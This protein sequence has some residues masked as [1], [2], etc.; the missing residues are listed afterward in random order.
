MALRAVAV[1]VGAV[2]N[3]RSGRALAGLRKL[4]NGFRRLQ[5][6]AS[7]IKGAL[8]GFG[9]SLTRLATGGIFASVGLGFAFRSAAQF[10][11]QMSKVQAVVE[12]AGGSME[13]MEA[14]AK[15]LG[16]TTVFSA[17]QA[18]EGMELMARAGFETGEILGGIDGI[19]AAAA[20]EGIT[21]A[22]ATDVVANTLKGMGIEA[23]H[24]SEVADILALTS[25]KTNSTIL[26]LGEGMKFVAPKARQMNVSVQETAAAL[27]LL[28]N[29][30][31]KGTLAGTGLNT[32]LT[33]LAKPSDTIT[34]KMGELGITFQDANGNMLPLFEVLTNLS[35][36]LDKMGGN[37]EQAAFLTELFGLRGEKAAANL[38]GVFQ[39]LNGETG[40][41]VDDL[42]NARGAA[43]KM[44]EIRLN[45]LLGQL[46][47]A[48]SA[49]EGLFIEMFA[50]V[51]PTMTSGVKR[52]V[53]AL[54]GIVLVFQN[55]EAAEEAFASGVGGDFAEL[56][57]NLLAFALGMRD[58]F[59]DLVNL[60]QKLSGFIGRITEA[61]GFGFGSD[62]LR[63]MA[64][65]G[66]LGFLLVAVL[67]TLSGALLAV[68]TLVGGVIAVF[69]SALSTIAAV[70]AAL[71][72]IF[73]VAIAAVAGALFLLKGE[74]ESWGDVFAKVIRYIVGVWDIAVERV[75]VFVD[76][77]KR[78]FMPVLETL[79]AAW[80]RIREAIVGAF[81]ELFG[82]ARVGTVSVDEL[83]NAGLRVGE[84]LASAVEV[85]VTAIENYLV[86]AIVTMIDLYGKSQQA[87]YR[88]GTFL[89]NV[90]TI[91]FAVGETIGG[92]MVKVGSAI[93]KFLIGPLETV[94]NLFTGIAEIIATKVNPATGKMGS[95]FAVVG[96]VIRERLIEPLV[97][98]M[99]TLWTMVKGALAVVGEQALRA[100]GLTP[101]DLKSVE[102]LFGPT[103]KETGLREKLDAR[104]RGD[105]ERKRGA[106]FGAANEALEADKAAKES[107]GLLG[108]GL[109]E[110][111]AQ[112]PDVNVTVPVEVDGREVAVATARVQK[113][114]A[115]RSGARLT[116]WQG[117][118]IWELGA[119]PNAS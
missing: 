11:S 92:I 28:H 49:A 50:I 12:V 41:L 95:K 38:V 79:S 88:V 75:G 4:G 109:K 99:R 118:R 70:G 24:A 90:G 40:T 55:A 53:E 1:H 80:F 62:S 87:I 27:G 73:G 46:T 83:A 103:V 105:N 59:V 68:A 91:A 45:N 33:K 5:R 2:F 39:E 15:S 86:P 52:F 30:G 10:E 36:G 54:Q 108:Q 114:A 56:G 48:K 57:P 21:L 117:R 25:A 29:A 47:L 96:Q 113:E 85:A 63:N 74:G 82:N 72:G 116:P 104:T 97:E 111:L 119:L 26:S 23:Q 13:G 65:A 42:I 94:W 32:M 71:V 17:T 43:E 100:I 81:T 89:F 98:F 58:A 9:S 76:G 51:G 77:L 112:R 67:G 110:A 6:R 44:A 106:W 107:E 102:E 19:L 22:Q 16:A 20:A 78:G 69:G 18:A 115:E 7:K 37:M 101:E 35:G 60:S 3:V 14:K 34:K 64:R 84:F 66:T 31:L 93:A 61:L 8:R